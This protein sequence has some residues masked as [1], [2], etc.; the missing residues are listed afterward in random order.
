[1]TEEL[2]EDIQIADE[3]GVTSEDNETP[4]TVGTMASNFGKIKEYDSS[5]ETWNS[6]VERL[7]F[8]LLLEE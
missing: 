8:F 3:G 5:R 7:E 1:M 4:S 2:N 6:Y